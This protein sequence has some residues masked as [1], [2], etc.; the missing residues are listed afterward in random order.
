MLKYKSQSWISLFAEKY[1]RHIFS[2]L[3]PGFISISVYT[4]IIV[5]IFHYYEIEYEGTTAVHSI[6]GMVLGFFLVFRSNGS[7]DRWWEGRKTWGAL[8]NNS[9]N[10]A[11]KVAAIVPKNHPHYNTLVECIAAYPKTLKEHL[12]EGVPDEDS[13]TLKEAIN[14][15]LLEHKP[16]TI[17]RRIVVLINEL[18]KEGV[19]DAEQYRVLDDQVMSLTDITGICERIKK[20]PIPYSYRMFTKKFIIIYMIT[21]PFAFMPHFGYWTIL[22]QVLLFYVLMSIELLAEEIEDPFGRDINDLPT[23]T[24]STTIEG[25]IREILR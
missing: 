17:A 7:Y 10:L 22:I 12:R 2:L 14:T 4:S 9:R 15:E 6:M 1:S 11:F 3:L 21:L 24:L 5:F 25:N 16:N 18:K 19:I 20:T 23:D 8:V 13:A